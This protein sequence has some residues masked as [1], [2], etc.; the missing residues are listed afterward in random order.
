MFILRKNGANKAVLDKAIKYIKSELEN[1]RPV[2][3][4]V[5][6]APNQKINEGTTDHFLV[7]VGMGHDKKGNYFQVYDNASGN[8]QDGANNSNRLYHNEKKIL[9]RVEPIQVILKMLIH[10]NFHK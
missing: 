9:L 7:I 1:G 2:F 10:I 3:I 5:D 6:D 8:V 4:G